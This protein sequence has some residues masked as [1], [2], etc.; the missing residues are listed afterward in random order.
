MFGGRIRAAR[1]RLKAAE[2]HARDSDLLGAAE[3]RT[4][5]GAL[6][7]AALRSDFSPH[8]T[9]NNRANLF[10]E[11]VRDLAHLFSFGDGHEAGLSIAKTM[12]QV[13]R[14]QHLNES[15][16]ALVLRLKAEF[17]GTIPGLQKIVAD[18]E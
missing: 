7:R 13:I 8:C 11:V 17:V 3:W 2:G 5:S 4:A 15:F 6:L 18:V 14:S 1:S 12:I 9:V 10:D 16:S